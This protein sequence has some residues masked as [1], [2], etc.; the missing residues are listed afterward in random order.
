MS[1]PNNFATVDYD[2][3]IKKTIHFSI[4]HIFKFM[5]IPELIIL[6]DICQ[7]ERTQ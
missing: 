7:L 1:D 6:L 5:T 3:H 4:N 2:A